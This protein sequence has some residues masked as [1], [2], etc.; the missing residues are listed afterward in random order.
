MG[1]KDAPG[2]DQAPGDAGI[3]VIK[4]DDAQAKIFLKTAYDGGWERS[5]R[6]ARSTGPK[7]RELM[8]PK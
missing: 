2:R 7:L 4:L 3:Q 8:A 6:P 1:S 5:S